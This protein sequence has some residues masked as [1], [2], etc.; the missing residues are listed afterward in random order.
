MVDMPTHSP[1]MADLVNPVPN[2]FIEMCD[3]PQH[4]RSLFRAISDSIV[5]QDT[6]AVDSS[7]YMHMYTTS[8]YYYLSIL[9]QYITVSY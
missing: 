9:P 7:L 5:S 4:Q 3:I 6:E 1:F 2:S 8:V